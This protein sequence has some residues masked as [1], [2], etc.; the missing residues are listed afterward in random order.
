LEIQSIDSVCSNGAP[1]SVMALLGN[2]CGFSA[3]MKKEIPRLQDTLFPSLSF[4]LWQRKVCFQNSSKSLIFCK[5]HQL[6]QESFSKS[7]PIKSICDGHGSEHTVSLSH[8]E[9]RWLKWESGIVLTR[10]FKLRGQVKVFLEE[11]HCNHFEELESQ[12]FTQIPAYFIDI[13]TCMNDI[14]SSLHGKIYTY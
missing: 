10:F 14:S 4:M 7:L 3:L 5:N 8:T 6:D 11:R 2:T 9:V 12:E 1:V 13:F